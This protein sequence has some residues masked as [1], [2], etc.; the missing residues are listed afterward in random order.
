MIFFYLEGIHFRWDN[1][2]HEVR[3]TIKCTNKSS[4]VDIENLD[5]V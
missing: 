5:V 2:S 1:R 3:M 4:R